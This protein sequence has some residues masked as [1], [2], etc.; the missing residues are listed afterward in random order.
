[1]EPEHREIL[2]LVQEGKITADEAA[3]LLDAMGEGAADGEE[4]PRSEGAAT[5]SLSQPVGRP[6]ASRPVYWLFVLLFGLGWTLAGAALTLWALGT[7]WMVLTVP[8]LLV[9]LAILSLGA[10]SRDATW[11]SVRITDSEGRRKFALDFPLPLPVLAWGVRVAR[12]FVP[13][14]RDTAVDELI[15]SLQGSGAVGELLLVDVVDDESGER[16]QVRVV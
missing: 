14:F 11:L 4:R 13:Q 5:E 3:R 9:G 1:M 8:F 2:R 7:G 12:P 15:L 16:V 10:A 6:R